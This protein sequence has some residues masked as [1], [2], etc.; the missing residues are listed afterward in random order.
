MRKPTDH[1]LTAGQ[2]YAL[3]VTGGLDA[4]TLAER[5]FQLLDEVLGAEYPLDF[6]DKRINATVRELGGLQRLSEVPLEEFHVWTRKAFLAAYRRYLVTPP[7]EE[8]S[9]PPAARSV[10][11]IGC[12]TGGVWARLVRCGSGGTRGKAIKALPPHLRLPPRLSKRSSACDSSKPNPQP[13]ARMTTDEALKYAAK[14]LPEGGDRSHRYQWAGR[15][16]RTLDGHRYE[17]G[18]EFE[19]EE[20]LAENILRA[21][22]WAK[23]QA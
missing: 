20:N 14:E 22:A 19:F 11:T 13:E 5:A 3:G 10:P 18:W 16:C 6:E 9:K 2:L 23:E 15:W 4:E 8:Q 21:A 7:N 12:G 17:W 1:P